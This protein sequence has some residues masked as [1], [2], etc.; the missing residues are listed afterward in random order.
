VSFTIWTPAVVSS[1]ALAFQASAWRMV[2]AQRV[3]STMKL[4]DTADE[5][6]MLE[7]LLE[8]SEP[9]RPPDTRHLNYLL[10]TP[11][12]YGPPPGGS[13]FR[14]LT[15]PGVFYGAESVRTASA[16]LGYW[17]WRFLR[18]AVDLDRLPPVA[19]T[20][21]KTSIATDVVDLRRPP[22]VADEAAWRD[23]TDYAATQAFA[24]VAREAGIGGIVYRSVRDPQPGWCLALLSR[25]GFAQPSPNPEIQTWFLMVSRQEVTWRREYESMRFLTADW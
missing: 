2:E 17:R 11:F 5:Q 18:D 13:R 16:E 21:F 12:H 23:P 1:E 4:V 25:V 24:R 15:D 19:H 6:N 8:S 7:S 3:A 20:A 9:L 22:F 10:A 14:I